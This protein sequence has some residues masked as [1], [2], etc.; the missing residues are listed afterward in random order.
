MGVA[1]PSLGFTL[2]LAQAA[3]QSQ[4][5]GRSQVRARGVR[6]CGKGWDSPSTAQGGAGD[7]GLSLN[8][9]RDVGGGS[10]VGLL[11]EIKSPQ[12]FTQERGLGE[13]SLD[14]LG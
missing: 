10:Q 2:P 14:P 3:G 1:L 11:G 12:D 9:P 4:G 5:R 8:R 6:G 13:S 7:P